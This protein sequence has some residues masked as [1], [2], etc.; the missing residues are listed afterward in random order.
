ML[1]LTIPI[2]VLI[3][4][5]EKFTRICVAIVAG[6]I[7]GFCWTLLNYWFLGPW[8]GAW[9]FPV[10]DCWIAGGVIG[11]ITVALPGKRSHEDD[12]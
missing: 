3:G 2:K 12:S 5:F 6:A 7:A 9:S 4:Q 10:V 8:F 1:L 11:F